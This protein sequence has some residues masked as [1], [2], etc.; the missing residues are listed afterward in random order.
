MNF[1]FINLIINTNEKTKTEK[2]VSLES[3]LSGPPQNEINHIN[4]VFNDYRDL[5]KCKCKGC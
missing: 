2:S 1:Y 5:V 4:F 3:Q